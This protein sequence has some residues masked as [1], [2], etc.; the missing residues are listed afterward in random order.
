MG[1]FFMLFLGSKGVVVMHTIENLF[2]YGDD[3][4][5][6]FASED[7]RRRFLADAKAE[8]FRLPRR[9]C[10]CVCAVHTDRTV[11][12]VGFVGHVRLGRGDDG[13]GIRIVDYGRYIAGEEDCFY[14]RNRD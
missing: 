5:V 14:R 10:D 8:G 7:I 2:I 13:D 4:W 6:Y 11:C 12:Y 1:A 9:F 3:V